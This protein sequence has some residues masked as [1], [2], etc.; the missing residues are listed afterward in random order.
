MLIIRILNLISVQSWTNPSICCYCIILWLSY[1]IMV[2]FLICVSLYNHVTA[3]YC[4]V[5]YFRVPSVVQSS[6]NVCK[7]DC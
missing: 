4:T 7:S 6:E 2:L 1:T 3:S 5:T